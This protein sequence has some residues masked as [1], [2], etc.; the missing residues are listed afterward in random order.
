[1]SSAQPV[2]TRHGELLVLSV[3]LPGREESAAGVLLWDQGEDRLQ[4]R[5]RMDWDQIASEEE[6]EVLALLAA[7]LSAK[8]D[9]MGAT[10]VLAYIDETLSNTLRVSQREPVWIAG[11]F[12]STLNRLY[13]RHVQSTVLPFR[14]HLPLY[15]CR[16]AAGRWGDQMPVEED[17]WVEAPADLRLSED[18]FVAQVVGR[19]MEPLIADGSFCVFRAG[20]TGSRQGKRV[21]VENFSE[22]DSGG[23]RY[24]VKRY[25]SLK[26][27]NPDGTWQHETIRLEPLNP[28][29][30]AW[31]IG[32]NSQCRVLAEFV[33]V[34][35]D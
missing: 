9:E 35:E 25:S 6:E 2:E 34:L 10:A 15:S 14:T 23:Q 24:T 12:S 13:R 28:A 7:D 20:V 33:R 17:G 1:M 22:S 16:A 31:E 4:A 21:L 29:F 19:S 27:Q 5:W 8:I 18:L 11:G 26:S 3:A 30:E 32:E